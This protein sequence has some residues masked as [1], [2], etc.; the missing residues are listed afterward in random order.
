MVI[1]QVLP[2]RLPLSHGLG[3]RSRNGCLIT[4]FSFWKRFTAMSFLSELSKTMTT[5]R[6]ERQC[7]S[8]I[9]DLRIQSIALQLFSFDKQIQLTT[10][11]ENKGKSFSYVHRCFS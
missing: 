2:A 9:Q 4:A 3:L 7:R 10:E 6:S 8:M 11:E 1:E 5:K